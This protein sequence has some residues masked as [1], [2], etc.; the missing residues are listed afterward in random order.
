MKADPFNLRSLIQVAWCWLIASFVMKAMA[1]EETRPI[2]FLVGPSPLALTNLVEEASFVIP[3]VTN[4]QI[5][6]ARRLIARWES[7]RPPQTN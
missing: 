1:V 5:H 3:L 4:E 7:G 2:Y 6:L